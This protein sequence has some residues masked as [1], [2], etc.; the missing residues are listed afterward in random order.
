MHNYKYFYD[1]QVKTNLISFIY[2]YIL[3]K[4]HKAHFLRINN[5]I[6]VHSSYTAY[7]RDTI[8]IEIVISKQSSSFG[9]IKEIQL[10]KWLN[11]FL[12]YL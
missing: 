10:S 6:L 5:T 4:S 2:I 12:I 3:K 8:F 1:L 9:G 7:P 11:R